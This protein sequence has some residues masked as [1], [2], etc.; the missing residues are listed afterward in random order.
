[1]PRQAKR[2]M[3]KL[4]KQYDLLSLREI[5]HK[6]FPEGLVLADHDQTGHWYKNSKTNGRAASVT[7]KQNV[8]SKPYLRQWSANRAVEY[9]SANID[10]LRSGDVSVLDEARRAHTMELETA[11]SIGTTAHDAIDKFCQRW[12]DTGHTEGSAADYLDPSARGEEVAAC[13]SFD[14]FREEVEFTPI[15]SEIKVWYEEGKD[16]YAGTVDSVLI[17]REV[18]KG[19]AGTTG[20]KHDYSQ[21]G[22]PILW[23]VECGR[24]V[25]EKLILGDWKTSNQISNKDEYAEQ[26]EAYA[27]AIEKGTGLKFDGIWVI[28]FDKSKAEYEI[29]K[30]ADRPRAWRRFL[31]TSR[32][33]DARMKSDEP[34]LEPLVKRKIITL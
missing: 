7:T 2:K 20:C 24:T 6:A 19:L 1:M 13:R 22:S 23:C 25:K 33:F 32:L 17:V 30:V 21:Q 4:S 8:V 18:Y 27:R 3:A 9:I 5:L 16:C 11:G 29:M 12:I 10:R 31:Q 14:K 15:A 34:L 28:R 26:T